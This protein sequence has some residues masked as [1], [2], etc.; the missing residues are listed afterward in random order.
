MLKPQ[1]CKGSRRSFQ[2]RTGDHKHVLFNMSNLK[3]S[4]QFWTKNNPLSPPGLSRW[5]SPLRL[6][7]S[8]WDLWSG[9]VT[10]QTLAAAESTKLQLRTQAV[11]LS[12]SP[13]IL[14]TISTTES[15]S[16]WKQRGAQE[17]EARRATRSRQLLTT[18]PS[19]LKSDSFRLREES[20]RPVQSNH[21]YDSEL[22]QTKT[23]AALLQSAFINSH[24][25]CCLQMS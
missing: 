19:S 12:V 25:A 22:R 11:I 4:I 24:A 6:S 10:M 2:W 14:T 13:L 1:T 9:P 21:N 16:Q 7:S 20:A 5:G 18:R 17:C 8:F 15:Q 3:T 23:P